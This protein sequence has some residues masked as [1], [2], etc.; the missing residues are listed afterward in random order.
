MTPAT[1]RRR[2]RSRSFSPTSKAARIDSEGGDCIESMAEK[3]L[4]LARHVGDV[5]GI[6]FAT[7]QFALAAQLRARF[8]DAQR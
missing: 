2:R 3:G 7:R 6:G 8:V 4:T 5:W 1:R